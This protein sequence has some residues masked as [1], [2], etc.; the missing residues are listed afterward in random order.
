MMCLPATN[1]RKKQKSEQLTKENEAFALA[2]SPDIR[3]HEECLKLVEKNH[4]DVNSNI[5]GLGLSIFMAACLSKK[6]AVVRR[7]L[8]NG[9]QPRPKILRKTRTDG[10]RHFIT[11]FRL[12][13][14]LSHAPYP[15]NR[16]STSSDL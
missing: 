14:R 9:W 16:P 1:K 2:C 3:E 10:N 13:T 6:E 15:T 8:Q 7:M 5:D 12:T 4:L 11:A